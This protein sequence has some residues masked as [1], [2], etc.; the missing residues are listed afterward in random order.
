M[1]LPLTQIDPSGYVKIPEWMILTE[2]YVSGAILVIFMPI[3]I[4]VV[5]RTRAVL[6]LQSKIIL[7][8]YTLQ[9]ILRFL[10]NLGCAI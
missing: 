6:D 10:K 5:L 4:F 2:A 3:L 8:A 9:F 1:D 7:S